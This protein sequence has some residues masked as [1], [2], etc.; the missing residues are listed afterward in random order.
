MGDTEVAKFVRACQGRGGDVPTVRRLIAEGVD[1]NGMHNITTGLMG[2]IVSNNSEI[3]N[4]L[5]SC[6]DIDVNTRNVFGFGALYCAIRCGNTEAVSKILSRGDIKLDN[7]D[8]WGNTVLHV[9][10]HWN[11]EEYV[12]MILA[13]P[14]CNKAIVN[15]E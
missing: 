8:Y 4:I 6:P 5:L 9:A 7:T 10:C 12:Q 14:S 3:V 13:H 11:K 15:K 1:I 2:A